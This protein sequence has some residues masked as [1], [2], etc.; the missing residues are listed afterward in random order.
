[1]GVLQAIK[2][3]PAETSSAT[4]EKHLAKAFKSNKSERDALIGILG[5]CGIIATAEHPGFMRNFVPSSSRE[6]PSRRFVDMAYPACWWKRTDG[7]NQEAIA[8]WFGHVL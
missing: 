6:L 8:Y 1:K 7:I 3:A 2:A 4:L 5:Y